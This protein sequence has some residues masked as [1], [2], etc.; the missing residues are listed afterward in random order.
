VKHWLAILGTFILV[1]V[2]LEEIGRSND[3]TAAA[4][5]AGTSVPP[6]L[7]PLP[8]QVATYLWGG[9]TDGVTRHEPLPAAG[10]TADGTDG[11]GTDARGAFSP[12]R[13]FAA[14]CDSTL[15]EAMGVTLK[16]LFLGYLIGFAVGIPLGLI[17]ARFAFFRETFG[18][19]ALGL[20]GLP[21]VCW[22]PLA[23]VWYSA[24]ERAILFVVVM[25]TV[26]SLMIATEQGVRTVSPLYIRAART[27]GSR[28]L[29]LWFRV[30]IPASLPAV[31][32][33]MKQG[34]AFAWRSLMAAEIYV[35]MLSA[36]GLG[37]HLHNGREALLMDQVI[38]IMLVIVLV[39]LAADR[40]LFASAEKWLRARW[41][42]DKH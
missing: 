1:L 16:R 18:L 25:G 42:L 36:C 29:H 6:R 11:D 5:P 41:G 23:L 28:G 21:S 24:T 20:Q 3:R 32:G 14:V 8:S 4:A 19:V 7:L 39:G 33:G 17:T 15:V 10:E 27:M 38:G 13:A 26:W 22:V 9:F 2:A 12:A 40:I 31:M 35:V 34:W 30:F 37:W